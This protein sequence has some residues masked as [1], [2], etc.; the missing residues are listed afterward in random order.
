MAIVLWDLI[1]ERAKDDGVM[2][3][4]SIKQTDMSYNEAMEDITDPK[5]NTNMALADHFITAK[6]IQQDAYFTLPYG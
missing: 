1:V 4:Y 2:F 3:T 6:R 5:S